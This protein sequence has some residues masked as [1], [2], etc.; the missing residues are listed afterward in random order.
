MSMLEIAEDQL[1]V[2]ETGELARILF[3]E[4]FGFSHFPNGEMLDFIK[5]VVKSKANGIRVF[6]FYPMGKGREVEPYA[7]VNGQFDFSKLNDEYVTY[8]HQWMSFL[9]M[10][11]SL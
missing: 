2:A 4:N 11:K 1:I 6:G 10:K 5:S 8:L 9:S 7:K 3:I